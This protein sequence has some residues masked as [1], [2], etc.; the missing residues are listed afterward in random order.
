MII[1]SQQPNRVALRCLKSVKASYSE[2]LIIIL[3]GEIRQQ[4]H[5]GLWHLLACREYREHFPV[6]PDVSRFYR[7]QCNFVR[8][9]A[10]LALL[11]AQHD[12]G[13]LIASKP[14]PSCQGIGSSTPPK[15]TAQ[16]SGDCSGFVAQA[17]KMVE[18]VFSSLVR[19]RHLVLP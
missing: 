13:Y 17:C 8:I 10:D 18:S 15:A 11:L 2:L 9:Y 1:S 5:Q 14:L 7:I 16:I 6:L 4:A 12:G 19:C 3:V